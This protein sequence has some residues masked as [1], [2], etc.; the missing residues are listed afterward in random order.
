ME[1]LELELAVPP[2]EAWRLLRRAVEEW[3]GEWR[4]PQGDV[5]NGNELILPTRA[6]LREGYTRFTPTVSSGT[7]GSRLTLGLV[8][9][10]LRVNSGAAMVLLMGAV[11]GLLVVVWPLHAA[12]LAVAPVGAVLALVAWLLVASRFRSSGPH[13]L[14]GL[15][16]DLA[17]EPREAE[18]APG[19][20]VTNGG[21]PG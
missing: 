6:G 15:V 7:T 1:N 11:G 12:L 14:L 18:V 4:D 9:E 13:E 20:S 8:G 3:G 16:R 19:E 21:E 17:E 5:A 10:S 2:E